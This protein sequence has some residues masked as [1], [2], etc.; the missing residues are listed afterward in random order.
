MIGLFTIITLINPVIKYITNNEFEQDVKNIFDEFTVTAS[1]NYDKIDLVKEQFITNIKNDIV[2]KCE[3]KNLTVKDIHINVNKEY[4]ILKINI[5]IK[6]M[7]GN[8]SDLNKIVDEIIKEYKIEYSQIEVT[9][10]GI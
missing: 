10:E 2:N 5:L 7:E 1:T 6:K 4:K 3:I 8:M 9:E